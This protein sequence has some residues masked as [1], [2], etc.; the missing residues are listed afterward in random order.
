[1]ISFFLPQRVETL[2]CEQEEHPC[3]QPITVS[4]D[5]SMFKKPKITV[6]WREIRER[7]GEREGESWEKERERAGRGRQRAHNINDLS[8]FCYFYLTTQTMAMENKSTRSPVARGRR[9]RRGSTR[10]TKHSVSNQPKS[11]SSGTSRACTTST[12]MEDLMWFDLDPVFGFGP[13]D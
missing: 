11:T 10:G 3:P 2:F 9:V 1:M 13:E 8:I 6:S 12:S 4:K 5:E 7:E